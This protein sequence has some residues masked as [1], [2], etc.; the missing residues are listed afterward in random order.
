MRAKL[1]EIDGELH[2]LMRERTALARDVW[3]SKDKSTAALA[4]V[5][6]AREAQ[7]LARFAANH[8][9][10][11][12]LPVLWR[13]WRELI[14]ANIRAQSPIEVHV[15]A[16]ANGENDGRGDKV[17][18]LARA[19]F[20]FETQMTRHG[21]ALPAIGAARQGAVAVVSSA[22][23][24]E[25]GPEVLSQSGIRIFSALPQLVTREGAKS[26]PVAYLIGDVE[27][28][29]AGADTSVFGVLADEATA[30]AAAYAE[31]FKITYA[32][33]LK[34]RHSGLGAAPELT[35][36]GVDGFDAAGKTQSKA[37]GEIRW[38]SCDILAL[39]AHPNATIWQ[40]ED[41]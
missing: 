9:G 41:Q 8:Q 13:I 16:E 2:R 28:E 15:A 32:L 34:P 12:P 11:M 29:P 39:G 40:Q 31:G 7:M 22:D 21:A 35:L 4:A 19:H 37:H 6:P 20:G 24:A 1:D 25:W 3:R 18:D 23:M 10:E 14:I 27:L 33:P 17:W 26:A 38:G 30:K 5:R 36:I